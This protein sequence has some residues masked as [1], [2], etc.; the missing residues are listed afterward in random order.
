MSRPKPLTLIAAAATG[1]ALALPG[2]ASAATAEWTAAQPASIGDAKATGTTGR[3]VAERRTHKP[4]KKK[5]VKVQVTITMET[6]AG[7]T[8]ATQTVT[9]KPQPP[10]RNK[11]S[12]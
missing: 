1:V 3:V 6:A 5:R 7:T 9:L 8:A 4:K 10:K 11:G 12:R 2:A